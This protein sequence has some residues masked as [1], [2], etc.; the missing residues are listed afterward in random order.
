[1]NIY[2]LEH[3]LR[4]LGMLFVSLISIFNVGTYEEYV[5][6]VDNKNLDF[7][8]SIVDQKPIVLQTQKVQ[9]INEDIQI[10]V[11]NKKQ[12]IVKE[13]KQDKRN[14]LGNNIEENKIVE[15]ATLEVMNG[16]ITG[17][18]P[19]CQGCSGTGNLACRIKNGGKH[20]LITDGIYYHD[21]N[22]GNVRIVAAAKQKFPCGTIIEITKGGIQPIT[23]IV[24]DRGASMNNAYN[25]GIIWLDL[26]YGSIAEAKQGGVSGMN[27][28]M[29]VK[30]WG[31]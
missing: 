25:N 6:N 9:E 21:E 28:Q 26:A 22:Y 5:L 13:E 12:T 3:L 31:W 11:V 10:P 1:M 27:F 23:A 7:G 2:L 24:L 4:W 19:D 18:G 29:N 15:T 30:R 8:I 20:S 16:R 14:L 17:Y